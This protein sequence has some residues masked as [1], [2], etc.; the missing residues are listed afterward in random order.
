MQVQLAPQACLAHMAEGFELAPQ[1]GK[2]LTLNSV[3]A[4]IPVLELGTVCCLGLGLVFEAGDGE[5][6]LLMGMIET[7]LTDCFRKYFL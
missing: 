6:G 2:W 5:E 1:R 4:G 3:A 7:E